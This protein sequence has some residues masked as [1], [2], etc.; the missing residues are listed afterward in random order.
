METLE[1][2]IF[3]DWLEK[4]FDKK[5]PGLT[6]HAISEKIDMNY[7]L[8]HRWLKGERVPSAISL[9]KLAEVLE[10]QPGSEAYNDMT[11]V[12]IESK[13]ELEEK[14]PKNKRLADM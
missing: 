9:I 7:S 12:Y 10:I 5:F 1:K 6:P 3:K 2:M 13:A 14:Q 8:V 11:G 4:E